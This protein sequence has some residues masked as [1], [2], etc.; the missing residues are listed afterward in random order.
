ME[1]FRKASHIYLPTILEVAKTDQHKD[2]D[3]RHH[4]TT[5]VH[6]LLGGLTWTALTCSAGVIGYVIGG[7]AGV[8]TGALCAIITG[9]LCIDMLPWGYM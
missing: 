9:V 5:A 2:I 6:T 4:D 3:T 8:F 1:G 7:D